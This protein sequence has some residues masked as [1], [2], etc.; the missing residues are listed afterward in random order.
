M[1]S[2]ILV[3][4]GAMLASGV[5]FAHHAAWKAAGAPLEAAPMSPD[6]VLYSI[7]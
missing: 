7:Y 6:Y 2:G 5:S 4:G 1:S 3:F